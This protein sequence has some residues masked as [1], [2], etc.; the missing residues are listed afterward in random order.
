MHLLNE[1]KTIYSKETVI[2]GY[3]F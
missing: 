2:I 3:I 1:K